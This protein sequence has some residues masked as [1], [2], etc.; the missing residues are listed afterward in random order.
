MTFNRG[1]FRNKHFFRGFLFLFYKGSFSTFSLSKFHLPTSPL[2]KL[3]F[4][5]R[6]KETTVKLS[7]WRSTCR[8]TTRTTHLIPYAIRCMCWMCLSCRSVA[9]AF[10][11][12]TLRL[13]F[14]LFVKYVYN[15]ADVYV[16][17]TFDIT[18][19]HR[20]ICIYVLKYIF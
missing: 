13:R 4:A 12:E 14:H 2:H 7:P 6:E 10:P 3:R 8:R 18:F 20:K 19:T 17:W 16:F 1:G 11:G 15:L 9:F 5:S